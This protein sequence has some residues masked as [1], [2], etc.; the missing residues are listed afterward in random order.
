MKTPAHKDENP[1]FKNF[2]FHGVRCLIRGER[3]GHETPFLLSL[4]HI[5]AD[6]KAAA[7]AAEAEAAAMAAATNAPATPPESNQ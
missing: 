1:Q 3:C 4:I 5:Y 2:L 6:L 7:A